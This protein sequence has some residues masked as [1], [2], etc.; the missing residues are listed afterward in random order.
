MDRKNM[1]SCY[2]SADA[3]LGQMKV[4]NIG[5]V[6][7]E[8]AIMK[9]PIICY[10]DPKMKYLIDGKE[11]DAPFIPQSRDPKNLAQIIDKIVE[12]EEFRK[13]LAQKEYEFVKKLSDPIQT[14][15]EWDD[16]FEKIAIKYN[17]INKNSSKIRL[18]FR[19]FFFLIVNRLYWY[20]MKKIFKK[21]N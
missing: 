3:V 14:A 17:S 21:R 6:E 5:S 12:S 4:G 20:K 9:K 8:A 19:L 13:D 7:R 11:I 10:Y 2:S 15:K 16:L 18:K 1:A